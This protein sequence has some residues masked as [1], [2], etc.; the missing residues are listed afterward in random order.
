MSIVIHHA[1]SVGDDWDEVLAE[2]TRAFQVT[3][4]AALAGDPVAYV[5]DNDDLLGR[6]GPGRAMVATGLL[7][8]A[9]TAALEGVKSGWSVNVIALGEGADPGLVE[10][11]VAHLESSPLVTGELLHIGPEHLGKALP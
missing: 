9:R 7:S 6:R 11:W 2:L 1:A 4:A 10:E 5:V 8:A 3:R